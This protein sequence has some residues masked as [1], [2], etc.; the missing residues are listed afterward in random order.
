MAK[1]RHI[2]FVQ[3]VKKV[4]EDVNLYIQELREDISKEIVVLQQY[5]E[6]LNQKVDIIADVVTKFVKLYETIGPKV[7]QMPVDDVKSFSS[8]SQLLVELKGMMLIS[9]LVFSSLITPE[10]LTQK[11][12]DLEYALHKELAPLSKTLTIF[13]TDAPTISTGVQR[14]ERTDVGK[15]TLFGTGGSSSKT[16]DEDAKV[17]GKVS[18]TQIPISL[19]ST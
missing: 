19:V 16:N 8:I 7:E 10:L 1:E 14:G 11:F 6:S 12:S 15:G 2:L 3:Y 5:Y 4:R 13:P 18:S 9:N 17:V